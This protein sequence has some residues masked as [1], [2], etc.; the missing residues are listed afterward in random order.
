MD[1]REVSY[2]LALSVVVALAI[3]VAIAAGCAG[4]GE[5]ANALPMRNTIVYD[6]LVIRSDFPLPHQHR[7]LNELK[8]QRGDLL[9]KLGLPGSDEPILVYLFE[10]EDKF[11]DFMAKRHPEFPTRRA[12]FVESDTRL[13][14][15]AQWG[16]RMAEDLRHEVAHGYLHS[17]VHTIP[18]WL[19]EGLAE[20]FEVP[21][22]NGGLNRGHVQLLL[23]R[24][25]KHGWRPNID[26][27]EQLA[28][29]G[30]MAQDDYAESWAWTHW[31]LDTDPRYRAM[32]QQYLQSLRKQGTAEP[33][34]LAIHRTI[35][36]AEQQLVEHIY[37]LGPR[38]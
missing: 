6:Q 15:Y 20:Y 36:N 23:E 22:G 7:L 9:G 5:Q 31:L 28:S 37:A 10:T 33:L 4:V 25:L 18:L 11:N 2:R 27:L 29:P 24:L 30:D 35:P 13:A 12:F 14:V 16:D 38:P 1:S 34:S 8:L 19:D 21:R 3:V 26:R 17:T 32:L